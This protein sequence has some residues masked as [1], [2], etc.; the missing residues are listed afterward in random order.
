MI[1][2][3]L[4]SL[5]K[6]TLKFLIERI[7]SIF[8]DSVMIE[9]D[10]SDCKSEFTKVMVLGFGHISHVMLHD[11]WSSLMDILTLSNTLIF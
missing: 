8:I 11:H 7:E 10:W 2:P 1:D 3:M 4:F 9:L 5:M 6:A